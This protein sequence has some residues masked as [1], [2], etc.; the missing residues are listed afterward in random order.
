L[1]SDRD[2]GNGEKSCSWGPQRALA[3]PPGFFLASW[4]VKT[5]L[6]D[7]ILNPRAQCTRLPAPEEPCG[8]TTFPRTRTRNKPCSSAEGRRSP[9]SL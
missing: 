7:A 1:R 5:M 8:V 6:T 4:H 9:M 2:G 3:A